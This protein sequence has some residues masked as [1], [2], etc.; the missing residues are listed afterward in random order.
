MLIHFFFALALPE[1]YLLELEGL[2]LR[3]QE[4]PGLVGHTLNPTPFFIIQASILG[5]SG[6]LS[7]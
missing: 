6:G 2:G 7:K 1:S 5:G 4:L 3:F